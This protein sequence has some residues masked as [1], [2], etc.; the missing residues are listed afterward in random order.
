V[1]AIVTFKRYFITTKKADPNLKTGIRLA[2]LFIVLV[3]TICEGLPLVTKF[4]D[5]MGEFREV[6]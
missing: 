1:L 4:V 3:G 2:Y 6:V 5:S